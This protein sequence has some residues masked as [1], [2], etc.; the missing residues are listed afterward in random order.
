MLEV[1]V[2]DDHVMFQRQTDKYETNMKELMN[3]VNDI[4]NKV[5]ELGAKQEVKNEF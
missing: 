5:T 4:Q 1:Q 2:N 3:K